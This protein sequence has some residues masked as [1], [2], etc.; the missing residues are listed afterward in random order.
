MIGKTTIVR[1]ALQDGTEFLKV[2]IENGQGVVEVTFPGINYHKSNQTGDTNFIS[3]LTSVIPGRLES[4]QLNNFEYGSDKFLCERRENSKDQC[5][6]WITSEGKISATLPIEFGQTILL[7]RAKVEGLI[8]FYPCYDSMFFDDLLGSA[9]AG[10]LSKKIDRSYV[11]ILLADYY[12]DSSFSEDPYEHN[13]HSAVVASYMGEDISCDLSRLTKAKNWDC[14]FSFNPIN[15]Q[16]SRRNSF[17]AANG[18]SYQIRSFV[19]RRP[20]FFDNLLSDD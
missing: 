5:R 7:E 11:E 1:Y 6:F 19:I 14:Y 3:N 13:F 9:L 10:F 17:Y 18:G 12:Y 4:L 16:I 2:E 15:L 20:G 8:Y